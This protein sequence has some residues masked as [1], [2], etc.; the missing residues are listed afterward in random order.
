MA[1]DPQSVT[2][3][4]ILVQVSNDVGFPAPAPEHGLAQ[5]ADEV[6]DAT[7]VRGSPGW[8]EAH[9]HTL[10]ALEAATMGSERGV[11][12][13]LARARDCACAQGRRACACLPGAHGQTVSVGPHRVCVKCGG[14]ARA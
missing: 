13:A 9:E 11:R 7:L 5:W 12:E 6:L 1:S 2:A 14:R 4:S 8:L 3:R 10:D